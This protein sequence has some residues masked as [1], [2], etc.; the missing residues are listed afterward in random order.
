MS[1]HAAE[2]APCGTESEGF[3]LALAL[4]S[5][6]ICWSCSQSSGLCTFLSDRVVCSRVMRTAV[7]QCRNRGSHQRV[8]MIKSQSKY[9]K[10]R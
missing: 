7:L 8:A 2:P 4:A 1:A 5:G 10:W 3:A 9:S 6:G